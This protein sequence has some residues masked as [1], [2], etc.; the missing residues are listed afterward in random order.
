MVLYKKALIAFGIGNGDGK[1]YLKTFCI[2]LTWLADCNQR[3][4]YVSSGNTNGNNTNNLI[5][6]INNS[7]NND[8]NDENIR[9]YI[10]ILD[11][12]FSYTN[13]ES[14]LTKL[15]GYG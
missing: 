4:Y 13:S 3:V 9:N 11:D 6:T 10:F 2:T 12:F 15:C 8:S 5:N 7:S 14:S 1:F